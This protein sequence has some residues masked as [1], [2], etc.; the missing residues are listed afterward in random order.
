MPRDRQEAARLLAAAALAYNLDAQVEY[1][2]ALFN[3]DGVAKDEVA[4]GALLQHA[5]R[6]G[7]AIAQNRLAHMLA[8]GR[9]LP[10]DPV[11]AIKWHI[12]AKAGGAGDVSLDEFAAKQKPEHRAAAEQAAKPWLSALT[13]PRS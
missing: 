8:A 13:E 2:I 5:A 4:A 3:G 12:V 6:R 11:H 1:A 7:S 9:G 10:A